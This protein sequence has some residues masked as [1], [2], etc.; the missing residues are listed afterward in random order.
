MNG[1]VHDDKVDKGE[2][3]VLN[4]EINQGK[5]TENRFIRAM[6]YSTFYPELLAVAY[7]RNPEMPLAAEGIVNVWNTRFKT[8]PEF[9][10]FF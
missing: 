3:L 6:D 4:R 8:S 5:I 9:V 7:D 2:M 1:S 10:F